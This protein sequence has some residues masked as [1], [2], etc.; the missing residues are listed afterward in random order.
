MTSL[1]TPVPGVHVVAIATDG[2]G[3]PTLFAVEKGGAL[4]ADRIAAAPARRVGIFLANDTYRNVNGDG[5]KIFD[6]AVNWAL[7]RD[8]NPQPAPQLTITKAAT[9]QVTLSWING[10]KLQEA[11]SLPASWTDSADQSNPQPRS[12]SGAMKFFRV[13]R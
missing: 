2:S 5:N 1:V 8:S 9:G 11:N 13:S 4:L 12:A 6:A 10:G 3:N 7:G